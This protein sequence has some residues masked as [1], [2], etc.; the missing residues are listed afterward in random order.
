MHRGKGSVQELV[1]RNSPGP[2]PDNQRPIV[3]GGTSAPAPLLQA[4]E[5]G[6]L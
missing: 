2:A 5:K 1:N 4:H 6:R 3:P